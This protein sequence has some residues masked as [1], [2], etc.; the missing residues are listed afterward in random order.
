M[1]RS[2]QQL[3]DLV[4]NLSRAKK[5]D[6]QVILRN[7][8]MERF[9]ERVSLSA[10]KDAFILKGGM[11][12]AAMVGVDARSTMDLDATVSGIQVDPDAVGGMIDEILSVQVDDGT[13]FRVKQVSAIMDATEYPGVRVRMDA[14]FD[15]VQV[16]MVVDISTGDAIT[17]RA[18]RYRFRLMFEERNIELWAYNLETILAEKLETVIVRATT[19]TRMR[20][21]YDIH[22]LMQLHGD[23]LNL[24]DFRAAL[25]AT[26]RMRGSEE[27]MAEAEATLDEIETDQSMQA[28][29][30][31]YQ[32][33]F[34]YA[35][36]LPW[37][38]VMRSIR[39]LYDIGKG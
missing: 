12:V 26:T 33:K 32:R 8:M 22:I 21:F 20:D 17:P 13:Q 24:A 36:D 23:S 1:I 3:K 25:M 4:R 35:A 7:Y 34:A 19:N 38:D 2:S 37:P 10:Y 27:A 14:L 6:A 18:V 16:P 39:R 11:L 28:L 30:S 31:S 29:W 5:A 15:G 9:L